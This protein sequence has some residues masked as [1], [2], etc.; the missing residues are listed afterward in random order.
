M[1]LLK[2]FTLLL[3]VRMAEKPVFYSCL[4]FYVYPKIKPD[5]ELGNG[6]KCYHNWQFSYN[7]FWYVFNRIRVKIISKK[8]NSFS[9]LTQEPWLKG[10]ESKKGKHTRFWH[11]YC[12]LHLKSSRFLYTLAR[13]ASKMKAALEV[14]SEDL[15]NI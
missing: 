6:I 12:N 11:L 8:G 15:W 7:Y 1:Q 3:K 13:E 4:I 2:C 10:G 9:S 5:G 14:S